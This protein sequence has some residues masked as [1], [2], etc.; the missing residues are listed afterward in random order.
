VAVDTAVLK[1]GFRK[2]LAS[3]GLIKMRLAIHLGDP[4]GTTAD[5]NPIASLVE[6]LRNSGVEI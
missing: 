3:V 4:R 2:Q 1:H 6:D 5:D